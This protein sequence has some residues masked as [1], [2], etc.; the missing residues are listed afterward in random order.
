MSTRRHDSVTTLRPSPA[1][2]SFLLPSFFPSPLPLTPTTPRTKPPSLL[3]FSSRSLCNLSPGGLD[4][5]G[6]GRSFFNDGACIRVSLSVV[7]EGVIG[8]GRGLTL[9]VSQLPNSFDSGRF[10]NGTSNR[11]GRFVVVHP[12]LWTPEVKH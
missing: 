3:P 4:K 8:W 10:P 1:Y 11:W 5:R 12:S 2:M 7:S 9:K 6:V